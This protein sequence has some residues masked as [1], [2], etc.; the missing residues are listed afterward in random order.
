[1][2]RDTNQFEHNIVVFRDDKTNIISWT[3]SF[4]PHF[5]AEQTKSSNH[6]PL[7]CLPHLILFSSQTFANADIYIHFCIFRVKMCNVHR[8]FPPHP[9][10]TL[11][12][13]G[14]NLDFRLTFSTM[15][16]SPRLCFFS[17]EFCRAYLNGT[18]ITIYHP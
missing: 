14:T 8:L 18:D 12:F 17:S 6:H 11:I 7:M 4:C 9:H 13:Y 3:C 16:V 15:H 10:P 5:S 1:M 2:G